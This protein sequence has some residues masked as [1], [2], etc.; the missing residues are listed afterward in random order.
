MLQAG[1]LTFKNFVMGESSNMNEKILRIFLKSG[2]Q[3]E[4]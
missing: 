4:T 1:F 3:K 2:K